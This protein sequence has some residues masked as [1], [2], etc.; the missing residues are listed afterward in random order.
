MEYVQCIW[1]VTREEAPSEGE[2]FEHVVVC[3]SY[4]L[5]VASYDVRGSEQLVSELTLL[6]QGVSLG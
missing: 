3:R 4:G 2:S 5:Q 6:G 1:T